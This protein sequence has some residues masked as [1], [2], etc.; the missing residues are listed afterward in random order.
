MR[1]LVPFLVIVL[2][3]GGLVA[4]KYAQ[5]ST[6]TEAGAAYA[7]AGPPPEAVSTDVARDLS[8]EGTL[9]AVG[10]IAAARAVAISNEAAGVVKRIRFDSG[11]T[12][13]AGQVLVELDTSV[14]RAQLATALVRKQLAEQT[15][16]RTA[17][18]YERKVMTQAQQEADQSQLQAATGEVET[19]RAQIERKVVRAPFAGRLGIR[20]VNLGQYLSPGTT[21]TTLDALD[22]VFVDFTLPQ[23]ALQSVKPGLPVQVTLGPE[24]GQVTAEGSIVATDPSLDAATRSIR[25]RASVPNEKQTMRPG[26]FANVA[27]MLPKTD[28]V[29]AVPL[30]AVVHAPYGDSVFLV[31]PR[32]QATEARSGAGEASQ[33]G[34]RSQAGEASEHGGASPVHEVR[35]QFVKLGEQRGD[36]VAVLS[37]VQPGQQIV[38][39]G[40]FKLRN[41]ANV[42]IDNK[43]RPDPKVDPRPENR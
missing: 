39:A 23:Q 34:E 42:I 35:Q 31:Q 43:L 10:T 41:G 33:A 29:V 4:V 3:V 15:A 12:A 14:E 13:K 16:A 2:L 1:Y 22:S 21:L 28:N 26:M 30:T 27:V 37:G 8:W 24:G 9:S 25:V 11:A 18:L 19:L 36:F 40:A 20:Q 38:T 5:I 6:L 17:Q 7:K 32:K